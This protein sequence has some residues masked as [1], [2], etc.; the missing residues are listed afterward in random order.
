MKVDEAFSGLEYL[1]LSD[2]D[3]KKL[4]NGVLVHV[5]GKEF[6]KGDLLRVYNSDNYF[7]ALGEIVDGESCLLLKSKKVFK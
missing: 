5:D 1:H 3:G 6:K 2:N 7:I 4:L